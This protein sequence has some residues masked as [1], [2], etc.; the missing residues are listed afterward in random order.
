MKCRNDMPKAHVLGAVLACALAAAYSPAATWRGLGANTLASNGD[1][2]EGGSAPSTNDAIVLDATG[3]AYPMTWDLDFP[4]GSWTQDGYTSTVTIATRYGSTGFTNLVVTNNVVLNSGKWTH[5]DN[6]TVATYRLCVTIGGSLTIGAEA[7]IDV[8]ALGFDV[9]YG[10]SGILAS[11]TYNGGDYAGYGGIGGTTIY[12][13][14][15]GSITAPVDLGCGGGSAGGSSSGGGAVM[16]TV[17]RAFVHN[18]AIRA[19]SK[20]SNYYTGSGGSVFITAGSIAGAGTISANSAKPNYTASGSGGRVAVILTDEDADFSAYNVVVLVEAISQCTPGGNPGGSGTIYLETRDDTPHHGWLVVKGNGLVP[21]TKYQYPIVYSADDALP[22]FSRLTLTNAALVRIEAGKNLSLDGTGIACDDAPGIVNGFYIDGGRLFVSSTEEMEIPYTLWAATAMD[23]A[24]P[25]LRFQNGSKLRLFATDQAFAGD[26]VFEPGSSFLA[27]A[28]LSVGGDLTFQTNTSTTCSGP[29]N[30]PTVRLDLTVNGNLTLDNGAAINATGRGYTLLYGPGRSIGNSGASHGG[31]GYPGSASAPYPPYGSVCNPDTWGSGGSGAAGGGVILLDI[32]GIFTNNGLV[33]AAGGKAVSYYSGAGGSVNIRAARLAGNGVINADGGQMPSA[34]GPSGGGRVA[35]TLTDPGAGFGDY[36]GRISAYGSWYGGVS[37]KSG[38]AG[39]VYLRAG[40]EGETEGTLIVDNDNRPLPNVTPLNDVVEGGCFGGV[41]VRNGGRLL[42]ES[43]KQVVVTGGWTNG[44]TVEAAGSLVAFT[45]NGTSLISG[46]TTFE[47][48]ACDAAGKTISFQ[49][50]STQTIAGALALSGAPGA[51]L[52]LQSSDPG[53][54]WNLTV[55][56][57]AEIAVAYV[58][59]SNSVAA[60]S[61]GIAAVNSIDNGGNV[62][63]TFPTAPAGETVTW[64]GAAGASWTR[65]ANWSTA[66][67]PIPTDRVVIPATGTNPVLATVTTVASLTVAPGAAL[68]LA[69]HALTVTGEV[70]VAGALVASAA[71]TV[72][73]RS[74]VT[75]RAFDAASSTLLIAGSGTQAIDLAGL[76]LHAVVVAATADVAFGGSFACDSF[77]CGDDSTAQ[78]ITFAAGSTLAATR[79][80]ADGDD[81]SA[82]LVLESSASGSAWSLACSAFDVSGATVSD[83]DA[84]GGVK[85]YPVA[86]A[87]GGGNVNWA[88]TD[89][90]IRWAGS[91]DADFANPANWVGGVVPGGSDDAYVATTNPVVIGAPALLGSLSVG[92]GASVIVNAALAVSN[93]VTVETGGTLAWNAPGTVGGNLVVLDGGR[94][95]H[96]VNGQ[97]ETIKLDL[98]IAG[99]GYVAAGGAIDVSAKGYVDYYGPGTHNDG[100]K[101][102]SSSSH[103]GRGNTGNSGEIPCYGSIFCPTN[104]GSGGGYISTP[105]S[106]GGGAVRLAFGGTLFLDGAVKADG[107]DSNAQ[108]YP[109]TGGSIFVTADSLAGSGLLSACGGGA[110]VGAYSGGGRIAVRLKGKNAFAGAILARGSTNLLTGAIQGSA[111]TIYIE[112]GSDAPGWGVILIDNAG[113]TASYTPADLPP[114]SLC[115]PDETKNAFVVIQ[116]GGMLFLTADTQ[117]SDLTLV[118]STS[119][120]RLNGHTLTIRSRE[121]PLGDNEAT[122]VVTGTG[123]KIIWHPRNLETMLILR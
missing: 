107:G 111:G 66:R 33:T 83:C 44:A 105:A 40:G 52:T 25:S 26:I 23:F 74:D 57:D 9:K 85:I 112:E 10:T 54:V 98:A 47:T 49:A 68:S 115:D 55:A 90:R 75:I 120:L 94:L 113:S 51:P 16:L 108:H 24:A 35:V 67:V 4:V 39:T 12:N 77:S 73:C 46:S 79:F 100:K 61:A 29:A 32:A 116:N 106:H 6:A 15:Y 93:S 27:D 72:T 21:A 59:V 88:F 70:D 65:A 103:G 80:T 62:N 22:N 101:Y 13:P 20:V 14:P 69:G 56:D 92:A 119:F 36:T 82:T 42:I 64:T 37:D 117:V 48:L 102:N 11:P 104:L 43:G 7:A 17:A 60:A 58:A 71:E 53:E 84:S 38:G 5:K 34:P 121:H 118:G 123:G 45:G 30:I 87:D 99:D 50:G 109:P 81:A 96:D 76:A 89:G 2:W 97:T 95:T 41:V 3:A 19:T 1:N 8:D 91:A 31:Q 63:W 18:G 86:S 122:Q 114:D 110:S 28:A 78:S